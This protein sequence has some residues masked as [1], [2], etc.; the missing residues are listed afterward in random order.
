MTLLLGA[1][2]K[3]AATS[4]QSQSPSEDS[5]VKHS[6][7]HHLTRYKLQSQKAS[8]ILKS[9]YQVPPFQAVNH[10][11][12]LPFHWVIPELLRHSF[13]SSRLFLRQL[14]NTPT[15]AK[16][17]AN[18]GSISWRNSFLAPIFQDLKTDLHS[19]PYH[20]SHYR[21]A[22]WQLFK[23]SMTQSP[24]CGR[25]PTLQGLNMIECSCFVA[26]MSNTRLLL[27]LM[28]AAPSALLGSCKIFFLPQVQRGEPLASHS[29]TNHMPTVTKPLMST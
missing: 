25:L 4:R 1:W 22:Q 21:A 7:N 27:S 19:I 13:H 8:K 15:F 11:H 6:P 20:Y 12:H 16:C 29:I 26:P 10:I 17:V 14:V 24:H 5:P 23:N 3:T 9:F 2:P 18:W 28:F